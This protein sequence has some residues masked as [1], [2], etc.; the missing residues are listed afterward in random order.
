MPAG[1]DIMT[2]SPVSL[3]PDPSRTVLRPF[4]VG[5]PKGFEQAEP[6]AH[7]IADRVRHMDA[8]L[9][10]DEL[11][12]VLENL[13]ERHYDVEDV[14][15]R[16][17]EE[18]KD[19]AGC[20]G[21]DQDRARL[22]GAYFTEEYSFESA[23]LFN[24]S[25]LALE[26][27]AGVPEGG[28][29]FALSLRGIGEGHLSSVTFRIGTWD[30]KYGFRVDPPS[31][32]A[33]TPQIE[34]GVSKDD[35]SYTRI[36]FEGAKDPSE[37]ILFPVTPSQSRGIEDL[38]M[39]RF[40][41]DDGSVRPL[42][43]YTAFNGVEARSEL[44]E[45]VDF[46]VFDLRAM[47]GSAASAKGM[48][49]FPRRINGRYAMLGRQDGEN[50]WYL[51]SD[52]LTHWD[53]GEIIIR[54]EMFWEYVQIGNC[55]APIELDEG[56]LVITH[57]VGSVRNYCIGACLLDRDDPRRVLKRMHLPLV[58][59]S[60]KERDGYV[61]NVVYSCGA[62]VHDRTLLLPY[63]VADNFTSFASV[64]VDDLLAAMK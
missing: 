3:R 52:D 5:D 30:P 35:G 62:L 47:T 60:P 17:F 6:R 59:P 39:T 56:W 24:P 23:A 37:A 29:R 9:L 1:T 34:R 20:V 28:V 13:G 8:D 41:E 61:P 45:A 63:G 51:E 40:V 26:D 46:Q 49:L 18:V 36:R 48:A 53:G 32:H 54:P 31:A 58:H 2:H 50:L 44:M 4:D 15:L 19:R 16:R 14:V 10:R 42:G 12:R 57:G 22:I 25:I 43:T 55:G 21:M 7:R 64:P 38:R 11:R 27:Q 33:I